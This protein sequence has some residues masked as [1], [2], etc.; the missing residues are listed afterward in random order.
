MTAATLDEQKTRK[1]RT[2][3]SRRDELLKAAA[4]CFAESGYAAASTRA[5]AAR[6]GMQAASLYCHYPSKADLLIGVHEVGIER[7]TKE[8]RS[9]I[10]G[11]FEPWDRLEAACAAHLRALL[12]G[13]VFFAA[14]MRNVPLRSDPAY[15]RIRELRD[16]YEAIFV[17]L[18]DA[19][20]LPEGT[21]RR[22]LRL[23][24][25][26][27]M[28]WSFT[29]FNPAKD[30]PEDLARTFVRFLRHSLDEAA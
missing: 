10:E 21:D 2:R 29:W 30:A 5:I 27:S 20:P 9:A 18:L 12:G 25:L 6:A 7:I 4:E 23:M 14:L 16:G 11:D 17:A 8:V 26:G 1:R 3:P 19:L 13:D 22:K 28:S 15:A 24:L